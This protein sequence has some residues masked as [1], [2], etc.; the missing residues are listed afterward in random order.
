MFDNINKTYEK[1][2]KIH[3]GNIDSSWQLVAT[4]TSE[5]LNTDVQSIKTL[6]AK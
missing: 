3:D 5:G 6:K 1:Q 2:S 4:E